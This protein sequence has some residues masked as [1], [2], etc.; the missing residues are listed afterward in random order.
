MNKQG[1]SFL[2]GWPTEKAFILN[3]SF[4]PAPPY[5]QSSLSESERGS[6]YPGLCLPLPAGFVDAL[7]GSVDPVQRRLGTTT[8]IPDPTV[9]PSDPAKENTYC[10]PPSRA[11]FY[12]P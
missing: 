8:F 4:P 9:S 2:Y 1:S 10:G 7:R 3:R 5:F 6:A 11:S 12:L